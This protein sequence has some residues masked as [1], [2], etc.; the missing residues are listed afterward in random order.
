MKLNRKKF[1]E[2]TIKTAIGTTLLGNIVNCT[3]NKMIKKVKYDSI[4]KDYYALDELKK[5]NIRGINYYLK[6]NNQDEDPLLNPYNWIRSDKDFTDKGF[7]NF[8][9]PFII[10]RADDGYMR[11]I[12]EKFYPNDVYI[13][14][15]T[16]KSDK[17]PLKKLELM[18][19]NVKEQYRNMRFEKDDFNLNTIKILNENYF[20]TGKIGEIETF[21]HKTLGKRKIKLPFY[22]TKEEDHDLIVNGKNNYVELI[23]ENFFHHS[24]ISYNYLLQ[25]H[26]K[27]LKKRNNIKKN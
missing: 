13:P 27:N 9:L 21:N 2:N 8:S 16:L 24:P 23:N 10:M 11:A 3:S 1:L 14:M 26:K 25:I 7:E 18:L 4:K 22:L 5:I 6:E 12:Q 20:C 17:T 19:M 15:I